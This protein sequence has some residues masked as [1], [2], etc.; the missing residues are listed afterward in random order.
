MAKIALVADEWNDILTTTVN[1]VI[2]NKSMFPVDLVTEDTTSL[3]RDEG[4][5]LNDGD[6]IV[7]GPNMDV[8]V[9]I[10]GRAGAVT[11]VELETA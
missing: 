1:T 8:S 9:Y 5:T 3:D 10:V 2:Q 7:V 4:L 11:V 6:A